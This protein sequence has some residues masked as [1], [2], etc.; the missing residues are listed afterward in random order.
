MGKR[1]KIW[2]NALEKDM[3]SRENLENGNRY[4]VSFGDKRKLFRENLE[5]KAMVA[6]KRCRFFVASNIK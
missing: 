3:I 6:K 1:G 2:S 4:R 5:R